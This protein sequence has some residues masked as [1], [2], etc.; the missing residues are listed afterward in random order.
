MNSSELTKKEVLSLLKIYK[1][2]MREPDPSYNRPDEFK[3]RHDNKS[4]NSILILGMS[5]HLYLWCLA[6]IGNTFRL[7]SLLVWASKISIKF[8]HLW[9]EPLACGYTNACSDMGIGYLKM[10]K[11]DLAISCLRN[12]WRVYPCPHNT[13]YGLK[14]KLYKKLK[15]YSE[16]K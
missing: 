1:N 8:D 5:F 12:A 11:I 15:P 6:R 2:W 7:P 13:S 3:H 4:G 9:Y 10:G 14:L 16:A